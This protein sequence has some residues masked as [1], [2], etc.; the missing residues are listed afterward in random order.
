[1]N[2]IYKIIWNKVLGCFVVASELAKGSRKVR[3]NNTT[4]TTSEISLTVK[5]AP[6]AAAV[7]FSFSGHASATGLR[8]NNMP[9]TATDPDIVTTAD[10]DYGAAAQGASGV[11]N[12]SGSSITTNGKNAYGAVASDGGTANL[13][14]VNVTTNGANDSFGIYA[15]RN[16]AM[17]LNNVNVTANGDD[18]VLALHNSTIVFNNG[19]ITGNRGVVAGSGSTIAV[20]NATMN[21]VG[22]G[23]YANDATITANKLN[24]TTTGQGSHG[25]VAGNN[26]IINADNI[27]INTAGRALYANNATINAKNI[28]ANVKADD[29]YGVFAYNAGVINLQDSQ[30]SVTEGNYAALHAE[31]NNS[32]INSSGVDIALHKGGMGIASVNKGSNVAENVTING[33]KAGIGLDLYNGV[34]RAKNLTLNL[35]NETASTNDNAGV[36]FEGN[37]TAVNTASLVDSSLNI[38]GPGAT[39]IVSKAGNSTLDVTN[40]AIDAHDGIGIYATKNTGLN[41]NLD[42]S[43]LS[44]KTLLQ[45]GSLT[46]P[47]STVSS[48]VVNASNSS[49]LNGD[50]NV[51]QTLTTT[52]ALSLNSHSDWT[53]ASAGLHKLN[54]TDGS[55]WNVTNSSGVDSIALNNST[56]NMTAEGTGYSKL[57]VGNFDSKNGT[58]EFKTHLMGDDSQTDQLHVTGDYSGNTNVVVKNAGGTGAQTLQGIELIQVDGKVDGS[59]NQKGRIVAGAYDYYLQKGSDANS[60]KWHL[61]SDVDDMSGTGGEITPPVDGTKTP[62][63][64]ITRPEAASYAANLAAANTLFTTSQDDRVGETRYIDPITGEA[65]STSLWLRNVGVHN[66]SNDSSGQLKT[67]SNRYVMQLGGDVG[68]W[69]SNGDDR[70]NLG[71]MGGY[72]NAQSNTHSKVTGFGSKGEIHGYSA[73][74]YGGWQQ[75]NVA[76][77]GAYLD[78]WALYNWFDNSVK[79]DDIGEESYKSKGITA[80]VEGG[81]TFKLGEQ[82]ARQSYYLQ[83]KAQVTWMG[84]EADDHTEGNGTRVTGSGNN[85]VQTRLGLRAFI[86]GHNPIDDGKGRTFEPF[87]EANWIH[88]TEKFGS[89]LNGVNVS[90]AGGRDIGELKVGIDAKVN[91]RVNL[92]GNIGQQMGDK[93]YSDTSAALGVKVNF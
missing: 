32:S 34:V 73:G 52:S 16:G 89:T 48:V 22:Y 74:V 15:T 63:T 71:V 53:G 2:K 78:S 10:K 25:L 80:S 17:N 5:L 81:Y 21:S 18:A 31:G 65:R 87:V 59:F 72:A 55:Q 86:K 41:V 49:Q 67:T 27:V 44:G 30:L 9:V 24:I 36:F 1:M 85:N 3:S 92:W 14:N 56:I 4:T 8:A 45:S 7:L 68:Q 6:L 60:G 19:N 69:T 28:T 76:K 83:P 82:S 39:G 35:S 38:S 46:D 57:T 79:G 40:S 51:N 90:Q 88:N 64:P 75:D 23:V 62:I 11:L 91:N 93:G 58:V 70:F 50:V 61:T 26:G 77:T 47:T 13:N 33:N 37:S 84:V 42:H 66:R 20:S 54:L 43:A 29:T 12:L